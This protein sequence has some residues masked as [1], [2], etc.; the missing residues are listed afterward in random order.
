[1]QVLPPKG[2]TG[3]PSRLFILR[4][5][6][7]SADGG[8]FSPGLSAI[9]SAVAALPESIPTI[10]VVTLY[11][12]RQPGCH[13]LRRHRAQ[14]APVRPDVGTEADVVASSGGA[15]VVTLQFQLTRCRWT[16]PSRK[17]PGGD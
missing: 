16:L 7:H 11:R 6:C 15:S 8:D 12:W 5:W 9:A 10:Q 14:R 3:G 13:D 1:M 4:P 2:S 17:Y